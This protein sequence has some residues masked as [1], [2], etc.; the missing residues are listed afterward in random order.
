MGGEENHDEGARCFPWEGSDVEFASEG[1]YRNAKRLRLRC[2]GL[3]G[4]PCGLRVLCCLL[5]AWT[6]TNLQKPY[7]AITYTLLET[8]S[9]YC[10]RYTGYCDTRHVWGEKKVMM[11]G[12]GVSLGRAV[13]FSLLLRVCTEMRSA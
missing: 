5:S 2:A 8:Q 4:G 12:R 11:R 9:E 13:M 6:V 7:T 1:V 3:C 10:I